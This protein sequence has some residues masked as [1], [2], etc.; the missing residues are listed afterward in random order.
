VE[1]RMS[2]K[3]DGTIRRVPVSVGTRVRAGQL[4]A[5]LDPENYDLQVQDAEA[6]LLSAKASERQAS[7]NYV[8]VRDLYEARNASKQDLDNARAAQ[9]SESA[10]VE[11]I[12]KKLDLA[13]NQLRYTRLLSPIAANVARVSVEVNENVRTGQ[14][15]VLLTGEAK[16]EVEVA[17][18][19][20]L[21][22]RIRE[23]DDVSVEFDALPG[24]QI[25]GK[26]TEVGVAA[27]GMA[28]TYPVTVVVEGSLEAMR[29][30]MAAEVS[31]RF[32]GSG[33]D[34]YTVRSVAVGEDRDGRFVYIVEPSG[35]PGIGVVKRREVTTAGITGG[36][37]EISQGLND[38][39]F[40]VT[41]GVTRLIDGQRVRFVFP[42]E[43][44]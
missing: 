38:G 8:R 1:S 33:A 29:S 21:I 25:S 42:Q 20:I 9:E 41:A 10:N 3:V 39:E 37:I 22:A 5:E 12:D 18:P 16:I 13:R 44:Q 14:E 19:E 40:V 27:T 11:S 24:Q 43:K 35:E 28:T 36:G 23:G 15:I 17:I 6:S 34:R 4:L 2:F 32:E 7:N 26:V 31:F 30:G